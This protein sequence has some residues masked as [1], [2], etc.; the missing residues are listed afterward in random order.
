MPFCG[1]VGDSLAGR[2][3]WH[4]GGIGYRCVQISWGK[5][6][7]G[8][9]NQEAKWGVICFAGKPL[10]ILNEESDMMKVVN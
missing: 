2:K 7:K 10:S 8:V 4:W 3:G 9:S 1:Q 6:V 5:P